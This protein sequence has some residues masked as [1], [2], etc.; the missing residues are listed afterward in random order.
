MSNNGQNRRM[1]MSGRRPEPDASPHISSDL[2]T[3]KIGKFSLRLASLTVG[4]TIARRIKQII[5]SIITESDTFWRVGYRLL[6][7]R[8]WTV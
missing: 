2:G 4:V 5:R 3:I 8:Y 6:P 7:G 1:I